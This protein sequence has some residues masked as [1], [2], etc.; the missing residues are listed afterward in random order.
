MANFI[1]GYYLMD[2]S[3]ANENMKSSVCN[4]NRTNTRTS[5]GTRP[6]FEQ[7]VAYP[8]NHAIIGGLASKHVDHGTRPS[9]LTNDNDNNK[10]QTKNGMR[11]ELH[12]QF[13]ALQTSLSSHETTGCILIITKN[14]L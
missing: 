13:V 3:D 1:Q 11:K 2:L 9:F 7:I 6:K 5:H 8:L 4:P 10:K 12:I 14:E